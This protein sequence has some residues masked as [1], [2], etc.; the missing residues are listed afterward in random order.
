MLRRRSSG[1]AHFPPGRASNRSRRRHR[2][3]GTTPEWRRRRLQPRRAATTQ[4]PPSA[5]RRPS[6]GRSP[7]PAAR[8]QRAACAPPPAPP[9]RLANRGPAISATRAGPFCR[10]LLERLLPATAFKGEIR[11][12]RGG[13]GGDFRAGRA[14][15][16]AGG[17]GSDK[18]DHIPALRRAHDSGET[19]HGAVGFAVAHPPEQIALGVH[20]KMRCGQV[21]RSDRQRRGGGAVAFA[22]GAVAQCAAF[23]DRDA[24]RAPP[25]WR[26]KARP[27][28]RRSSG[29][30]SR[31][32]ATAA[33]RPARAHSA[34][35]P[36]VAIIVR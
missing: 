12:R 30:R 1:R 9:A 32:P 13:C 26:H 24:R 23:G 14:R 27:G 36:Q 4:A 17:S 7:G 2:A 5:R 20:E 22:V 3:R 11:H 16:N 33:A 34:S 28:R 31:P 6:R 15:Q 18:I 19:W 8:P 35:P 10:T 21:G 29:R 25:R